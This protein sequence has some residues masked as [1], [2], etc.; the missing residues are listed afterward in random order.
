MTLLIDF[1]AEF[2]D[3]LITHN[4]ERFLASTKDADGRVSPSGFNP[5]TFKATYPQPANANDLRALDQGSTPSSSLILHSVQ[6]LK[7]TQNGTKGDIVIWEGDRYL[8][9]QCNKRNHQAGNYRCL[10][11]KVQAGE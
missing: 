9:M 7:I 6:R 8:V 5:F 4:G 11:K 2:A 10:I 3:L 1:A